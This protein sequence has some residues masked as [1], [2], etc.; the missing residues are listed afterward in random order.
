[1]SEILR[2]ARSSLNYRDFIPI[3]TNLF[4]RMINQGLAASNLFKQIDK[5]AKRHPDSF[6]SFNQ[7]VNTIKSDIEE[8]NR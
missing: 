8:H 2:I 1:M 7:N 3:T 6:T 5:V 4:E